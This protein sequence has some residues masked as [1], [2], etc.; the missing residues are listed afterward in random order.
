MH[1]WCYMCYKV[2]CIYRNESS[3]KL[4]ISCPRTRSRYCW[5]WKISKEKVAML[6]SIHSTGVLRLLCMLTSCKYVAEMTA[7]SLWLSLCLP[8]NSSSS[9]FPQRRILSTLLLPVFYEWLVFE[10]NTFKALFK[11]IFN[12][13]F[14]CVCVLKD[15]FYEQHILLAR[16]FCLNRV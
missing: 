12:K 11:S 7:I 13:C 9:M 15:L 5:R 10:A 6:Y 14:V 4:K 3:V 1:W 8:M 16:L 2:L